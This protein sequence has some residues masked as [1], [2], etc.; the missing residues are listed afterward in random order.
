MNPVEWLYAWEI[1]MNLFLCDYT[2]NIDDITKMTQKKTMLSLCNV[3]KQTNQIV[4]I[5]RHNYPH[6]LLFII[7]RG[8]QYKK[9]NSDS[10]LSVC[11]KRPWGWSESE[12]RRTQTRY[13]IKKRKNWLVCFFEK[14]PTSL[15]A[16]HHRH[17]QY[18]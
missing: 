9:K 15:E 8:V 16:R 11:C 7:I 2:R 17:L 3:N 4:F 1:E 18:H 13:E 5:S 6:C 14:W 12:S 10:K